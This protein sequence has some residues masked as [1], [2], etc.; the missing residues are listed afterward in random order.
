[1]RF[2]FVRL[3]LAH[4]YTVYLMR[5]DVVEV[6]GGVFLASIRVPAGLSNGLSR[7]GS[8]LGVSNGGPNVS[9][10][11]LA[12]KS[13]V[14]RGVGIAVSQVSMSNSVGEVSSGV[15]SSSIAIPERGQ[16]PSYYDGTQQNLSLLNDYP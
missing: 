2:R 10:I 14:A 11:I 3:F 13:R 6:V 9:T 7:D 4:K 15:F 5:N 1:L 16:T 8:P 12:S